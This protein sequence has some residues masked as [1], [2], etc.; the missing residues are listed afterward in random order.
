MIPRS[1]GCRLCRHED[2]RR[3][4]DPRAPSG[5]TAR[6]AG[7]PHARS[8]LGRRGVQSRVAG[9]GQSC[10]HADLAAE[11]GEVLVPGAAEGLHHGGYLIGDLGTAGLGGAAPSGDQT[12]AGDEA[13]TVTMP[14]T[15]GW[16]ALALNLGF[17]GLRRFREWRR[18][19]PS[20]LLQIATLPYI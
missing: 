4:G 12:A 9:P 15:G 16:A 13:G 6:T 8:P 7:T 2:E 11:L 14:P 17:P 1:G 5:P 18:R 10:T 19:T 3:T 20:Q